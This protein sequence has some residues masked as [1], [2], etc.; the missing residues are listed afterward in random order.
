MLFVYID[1]TNR[2]EYINHWSLIFKWLKKF[3]SFVKNLMKWVFILKN[4][5][6]MNWMFLYH[7]H[8]ERQ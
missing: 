2:F 6:L 4:L 8:M 5:I 7:V 3:N 1:K